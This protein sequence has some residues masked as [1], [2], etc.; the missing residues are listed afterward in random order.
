VTPPRDPDPRWTDPRLVSRYAARDDALDRELAWP[1]L[2]R[3]VR[4]PHG[5]RA[6]GRPDGTVLDFGCGLGEFSHGLVVE[7]WVRAFAVDLSAAMHRCG[8]ERLRDAWLVRTVPDRAGR[9]PLRPGQCTAACAHLVFTH[10]AHICLVLAAL[11][12]IR[13]VLRPGAPLAFTEPGAYGVE[14]P[15]VRWGEPGGALPG[16][17][18]AFRAYYRGGPAAE[19]TAA[20]WRYSPRQL[21]DCLESAGFHVQEIRPLAARA[22]ASAPF[23]LWRAVAV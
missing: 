20:A 21:A 11:T 5:C 9:L 23:V 8:A 4:P 7:H 12:E 22:D 14:F 18:E 19:V 10:L 16:A 13:R 15:G 6:L 3:A 2:A 17:G 1:E